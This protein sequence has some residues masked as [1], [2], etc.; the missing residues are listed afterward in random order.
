MVC[1]NVNVFINIVI[2]NISNSNPRYTHREN[3]HI[4]M[5]I[6]SYKCGIQHYSK[7]LQNG[8]HLTVYQQMNKQT[9]IT[10]K[11]NVVL[12]QIY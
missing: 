3:K 7:Y 11:Y 2:K 4:Y 8:N 9:V 10:I 1:A 5:H 12:P 6:I